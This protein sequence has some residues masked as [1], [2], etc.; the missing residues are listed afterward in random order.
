MRSTIPWVL[1]F[2]VIAALGA[3]AQ[4]SE[5]NNTYAE[6]RRLGMNEE[7]A[8]DFEQKYSL[9]DAK[10][11]SH[12]GATPTESLEVLGNRRADVTDYIAFRTDGYSHAEAMEA[13][14]WSERTSYIRLRRSRATHEQAK[15]VLLDGLDVDAYARLRRSGHAHETALELLEK[16]T[17]T[18]KRRNVTRTTSSEKK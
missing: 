11:L 8:R 9:E 7:H 16:D 15:F 6:L 3:H 10:K 4:S 12:A 13:S 17:P 2:C 14:T 5:T 1:S 18:V